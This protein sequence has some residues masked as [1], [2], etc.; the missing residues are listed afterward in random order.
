MSNKLHEEVK[1]YI[2]A[3][4]RHYGF[5]AQIIDWEIDNQQK[6][7]CAGKCE[8]ENLCNDYDIEIVIDETADIEGDIEILSETQSDLKFIIS[9]EYNESISLPEDIY[10]VR[11]ESFENIL[12]SILKIPENYAPYTNP[13]LTREIIRKYGEEILYEI[14]RNPQEIMNTPEFEGIVTELLKIYKDTDESLAIKWLNK[15]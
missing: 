5:N 6:I 4:L 3:V 10:G 11:P 7:I 15:I 1:K 13:K 8:L 14:G 9:P 2:I 12:R